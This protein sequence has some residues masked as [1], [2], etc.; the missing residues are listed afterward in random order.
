M[1][2]GES[3]WGPEAEAGPKPAPKPPALERLRKAAERELEAARRDLVE[4][5]RAMAR[6]AAAGLA[7]RVE[8]IQRAH[9]RLR[10]LTPEDVRTGAEKLRAALREKV[11]RRFEDLRS[12]LDWQTYHTAVEKDDPI[13]PALEHAHGVL[14]QRL[15]DL[16]QHIGEEKFFTE[17]RNL[18]AEKGPVHRGLRGLVFDMHMEIMLDELPEAERTQL[19]DRVYATLEQEL[20]LVAEHYFESL[21]TELLQGELTEKHLTDGQAY[22]VETPPQIQEFGTLLSVLTLLKE[23]T[24]AT[25]GR[26]EILTKERLEV[27]ER[28]VR[29]VLAHELEVQA[30]ALIEDMVQHHSV[31][32]PPRPHVEDIRASFGER[33]SQLQGTVARVVSYLDHGVPKLAKWAFKAESREVLEVRQQTLA[34]KSAR[35]FEL[36]QYLPELSAEEQRDALGTLREM[37]Q[38]TPLDTTH[39]RE[40]IAQSFIADVS[41]AE[42]DVEALAALGNFSQ[43]GG[44]DSPE[45]TEQAHRDFL[46]SL[47]HVSWPEFAKV[48][49]VLHHSDLLRTFAVPQSLDQLAQQKL[50]LFYRT[51]G[52]AEAQKEEYKIPAEARSLL[53]LEQFVRLSP[54]HLDRDTAQGFLDDMDSVA[55]LARRDFVTS[56]MEE[57]RMFYTQICAAGGIAEVIEYT[58]QVADR[59]GMS[60]DERREFL[61]SPT[62][63]FP[64]FSRM[65]RERVRALSNI[66]IGRCV[67]EVAWLKEHGLEGVLGEAGSRRVIEFVQ[68]KLTLAYSLSP[69]KARTLLGH[70]ERSGLA[71][72]LGAKRRAYW[73]DAVTHGDGLDL[74]EKLEKADVLL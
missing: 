52:F 61:L 39:I 67:E 62:G 60:V 74:R 64:T 2:T 31:A 43:V 7:E 3:T 41:L 9:E 33:L 55:P 48:I 38:L 20:G 11:E 69:E 4:P 56:H 32:L 10:A 13:F 29:H 27:I 72:L 40:A 47:A 23:E 37:S 36:V 25:D 58:N 12:T 34:E 66:D 15:M 68:F 44:V 51:Y 50:G 21:A 24:A 49:T 19:V 14:E 5:A 46:S 35:L 53:G 18:F 6:D 1:T 26:L 22:V 71:I 28:K 59:M 70:L 57:L 8:A 54:S 65:A 73:Q 45:L 63:P 17:L 30:T 16:S 42:K